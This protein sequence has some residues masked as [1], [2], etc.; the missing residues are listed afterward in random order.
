MTAL[1]VAAVCAGCYLLKAAGFVIPP[2]FLAQPAVERAV[3]VLPV[4]VLASLAVSGTFGSTHGFTVDARVAGMAV[5]AAGIAL[6]I[7]LAGVLVLAVAAT[8]VT[9]LL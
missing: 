8:A 9:R 5:A 1:A 7:P 4:A 3:A 6:R 2:R